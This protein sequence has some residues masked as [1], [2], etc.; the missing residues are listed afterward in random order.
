MSNPFTDEKNKHGIFFTDFIENQIAPL[1]VGD[2][3]KVDLRGESFQKARMTIS[4]KAKEV[5][6][7]FKTKVSENELWILRVK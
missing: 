5:S 7:S 2:S 6:K 1:N 4:R 3:K